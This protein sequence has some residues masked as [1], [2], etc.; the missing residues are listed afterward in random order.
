MPPPPAPAPR[1]LRTDLRCSTIDGTFYMI[2][3][4]LAETFFPLFVLRL[5]DSASASGLVITLPILIAAVG[6][7]AARRLLLR[8]GSYRRFLVIGASLQCAAC[9]PLAAIA[10]AGAWGHVAPGTVTF[11][12]AAA[13]YAGAIVAGPV[14]TTWLSSVV[15]APLRAR[16]FAGR[17]RWLQGGAI[18]GVL[19]GAIILHLAETRGAD[20]S[21]VRTD[22]ATGGS[23]LAEAASVDVQLV[24]FA[25]LFVLAGV[26]R[27]VSTVYLAKHRDCRVETGQERSVGARELLNR[28]VGRRDG[29][30]VLA[31]VVF[32]FALMIGAPFWHAFARE[33]VGIGFLQWAVLIAAQ[34]FGRVLVLPLAGR[35]AERHGATWMLRAGVL[36]TIPVPVL[37]CVGDHPLWMAA[38]MMFS[39]IAMAAF[40]FGSF[41]MIVENVDVS[42]RT[43]VSAR[44]NLLN[45]GAASLGASVGGGVLEATAAAVSS[46]GF[47]KTFLVSAGARIATAGLFWRIPEIPATRVGEAEAAEQN[48]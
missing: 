24:G 32:Q 11:L 21:G 3:V 44:F 4:G 26:C 38:T 33:S 47:I 16:Y 23:T 25:A 12:A 45:Y 10:L 22:D 41:L 6:Q 18:I 31:L 27:A 13:Y 30:L 20:G 9:L 36:C 40:E 28:V 29:R 34:F 43:S 39:G 48:G 7:L 1:T 17:N 19:G 2:M 42:E 5:Y 35:L 15:P 14:W 46:A 37:W 8:L